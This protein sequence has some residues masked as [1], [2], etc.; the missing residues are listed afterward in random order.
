[1]TESFDLRDVLI[2]RKYPSAAVKIWFTEEPFFKIARLMEKHADAQPG[3]EVEEMDRLLDE[4]E[5]E[6]DNIAYTLYVKAISGRKREDLQSAALSRYPIKRDQYGLEDMEQAKSRI[7]YLE[8]HILRAQITKLV[9]PDGRERLINEDEEGLV[10]VR[11]IMDEAPE[12]TI[13]QINSAINQVQG[14]AEMDKYARMDLDFL[15]GN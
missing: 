14:R 3:A 4:A 8:E 6:R 15:S 9:A 7:R 10:Q 2:G 13:N 11:A 5:R 12:F 1:M